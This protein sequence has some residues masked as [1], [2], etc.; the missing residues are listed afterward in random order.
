MADH[1]HSHTH[2]QSGSANIRTAFF[3]NLA[4]TTLE[5]Y[6]GIWTNNLAILSDALHDLDDSLSL[7]IAWYLERYS[8]RGEDAKFSYGYRRFSLV[9]ALVN[10][11]ILLVGSF[12]ILTQA[13]PRL[14]DPQHSNA[15]GMAILALIGIA[16]N[17]LAVARL[18]GDK[19]ENAKVVAWHLLEDVLGWV[20]VL[21]VSIVLLFADIHILDPILS[22]LISLYILFNVVRNLKSTMALFLQAVPDTIN[23]KKIESGIG[24]LEGVESSHHVHAWSLEGQNHLLTMHVVVAEKAKQSSVIKLRKQIRTLLLS[25]DLEH[26]TIEIEYGPHDCMLAA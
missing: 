22:I 3:L 1:A 10:T 11:I 21:I 20:A 15:Q 18:R 24:Q 7:G 8:Q 4:F 17:G 26:V 5:I 14:L 23:L 19:S 25:E 13:I 9:G 2:S 12:I 6:G 16:V